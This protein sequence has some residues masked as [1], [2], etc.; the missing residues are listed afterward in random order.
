M[1]VGDAKMTADRKGKG[2]NQD[3]YNIRDLEELEIKQKTFKKKAFCET[4]EKQK[5]CV[6]TTKS[7]NYL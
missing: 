4:G 7:N 6:L 2:V 5:D 3:C 1:T